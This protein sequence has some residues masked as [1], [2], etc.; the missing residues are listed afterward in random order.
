MALGA[1]GRFSHSES[2]LNRLAADL[3]FEVAGFEPA[4]TRQ[5]RGRDV[6]GFIAVLA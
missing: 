6:P 2:Y 1:D 5:D 3:D 4:S